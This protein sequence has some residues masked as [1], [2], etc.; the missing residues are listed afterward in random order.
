MIPLAVPAGPLSVLCLGAHADD[1]EIGCGGTLLTLAAARPDLRAHYVV[2]T[3]S[4]VRPDEARTAAER[5]LAG[6]ELTVELHSLPDGRLPSVWGEVKQLLQ[7]VAATVPTPDLIFAPRSDDAHQDHRLLAELVAT[8]WRDSLVLRYEIPKWDADRGRVT[9]YVPLSDELAD[10]KIALLDECYPSQLG[11][12]WWDEQT[13][14]GLLRLRGIEC[15][16]RYAEAFEVGKAL[17][18]L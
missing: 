16:A 17:V 11:R 14:R 5:F 1:I 15:R 9:H 8:V 3:G 4:G 6:A 12:D 2:L 18:R 10:R 7:D 13:F